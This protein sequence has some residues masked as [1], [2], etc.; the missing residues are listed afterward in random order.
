MFSELTEA[1]GSELRRTVFRKLAELP[2][3]TSCS[4][5]GKYYTLRA[6]CRFDASGLWCNRG[7]WFSTCGTLLEAS[8]RFVERVPAGYSANELDNA[9]HVRTRQ[10]LLA[11]LH[12]Q[13]IERERIGGVFIYLALE[14]AERQRQIT[15]RA[16]IAQVAVGVCV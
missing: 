6:A 10:T 12:R 9:H 8:R 4:H 1:L 5:R 13:V 2:Y 11:L 16:K 15:A 14:P 3:L 7:I